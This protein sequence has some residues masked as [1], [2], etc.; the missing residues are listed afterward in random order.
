MENIFSNILSI[1]AALLLLGVFITVHELGHFLVARLL[2]F[3]ILEFAVGMG[4]KIWG[5]EKNGTLFS[6]RALPL[7][8]M[9]RFYGED[10][11]V[12]DGGGFNDQKVW[13]R[14]LV[15]LSG[16]LCN[17]IMALLLGTVILMGYGVYT[18]ET[19]VRVEELSSPSAPAAVSGV[20]T[21]D[22]IIAVDGVKVITNDEALTAIG[23]AKAEGLTLTVLRDGAEKEILVADIYNQQEDKN[24]LGVMV[25][26]YY[27]REKQGLFDAISGT[28]SYAGMVIKETFGVLGRLITGKVEQGE[29]GGVVAIVATVSYAVRTNLEMVLQMAMLISI[30]L[31]IMNL[32]P[33]PALDGG[34]L[35]FLMIEGIR[36]KPIS[37]EKE[38]M[39]HFIGFA[40]LM[41]LMVFLVF[42]DIRMLSGS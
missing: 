42:S 26:T 5:K 40:L 4:P 13:K 37:P 35:V 6:L 22:V 29:V 39:V 33:I 12:A 41:V 16:P 17:L 1:I 24:M 7:G 32:L 11:G 36:R 31:G 3:R 8:G 28:F 18:N 14:I 15:V 25:G 38:G 2:K 34:R 30:S 20:E 10:E 27:L 19:Q 9:C 23:A 21:G